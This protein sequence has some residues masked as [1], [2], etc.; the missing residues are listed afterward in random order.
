[1]RR[2]Y[3]TFLSCSLHSADHNIRTCWVFKYYQY[4]P[5]DKMPFLMHQ[6]S[7]GLRY[8]APKEAGLLRH[9]I[10]GNSPAPEPILNTGQGRSWIPNDPYPN[11]PECPSWWSGVGKP[12]HLSQGQ[13]LHGHP[14]IIQLRH[15]QTHIKLQSHWPCQEDAKLHCTYSQKVLH[16]GGHWNRLHFQWPF[17]SSKFF[18]CHDILWH[19]FFFTPYCVQCN[20]CSRARFNNA[21]HLKCSQKQNKSW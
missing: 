5:V 15:F 7:S 4:S 10:R 18:K 3:A 2:L 14:T 12:G 13:N 11:I 20:R 1:M 8:N 21:L 6:C 16:I 19:A 17:L 9:N